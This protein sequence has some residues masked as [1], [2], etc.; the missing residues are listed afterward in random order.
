MRERA[1]GKYYLSDTIEFSF[2]K[3]LMSLEELV[4]CDR[5]QE[6]VAHMIQPA[7]K[8]LDKEEGQC[9][10]SLSKSL[11][12][13]YCGTTWAVYLPETSVSASTRND[14]VDLKWQ[15]FAVAAC[16]DAETNQP[17]PTSHTVGA[18][19]VEDSRSSL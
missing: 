5:H 4:G 2:V 18:V 13:Q 1:S 9:R 3:S 17:S 7:P 15:Y 10:L 14:M 16:R 11:Y 12:R 6:V 19:G 8:V